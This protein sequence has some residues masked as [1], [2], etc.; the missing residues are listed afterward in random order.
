MKT[1]NLKIRRV[2]VEATAMDLRYHIKDILKAL[3]RN[4]SVD[5]FYRGECKGTII[6][7]KTKALSKNM[8]DHPACGIYADD[9]RSVS[10]IVHTLRKGRYDDL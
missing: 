7:K 8:K 9:T 3:A 4:E 2:S 1:I 6:P 10:D 5:I